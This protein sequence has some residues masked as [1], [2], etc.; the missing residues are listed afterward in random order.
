MHATAK[1]FNT[2]NSQ[3]VRLP[4]AFRLDAVEVWIMRNE[5]SGEIILQPKPKAD[6]LNVFFSMLESEPLNGPEF[7]PPRDD[8]PAADPFVDWKAEDPA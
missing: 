4:K 6:E 3:A 8:R 7:I 2:G 5:A 1:L